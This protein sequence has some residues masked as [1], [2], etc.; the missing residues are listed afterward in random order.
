MRNNIKKSISY[1]I[2]YEIVGT[3]T[4]WNN[5][6]KSNFRDMLTAVSLSRVQYGHKS[7]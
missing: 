2:T 3:A 1:A 4:S 5:Y 6:H 7:V